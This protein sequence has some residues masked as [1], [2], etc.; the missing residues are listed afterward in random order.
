MVKIILA[1]TV[2]LLSQSIFAH[3]VPYKGAVGVM[4]WNQP[5]MSDNWL[6][7]SFRP[8]MAVAA[9]TMRMEMPGEE[10]RYHGAQLDYLLYRKNASDY[11]ANVY[12]YGGGGEVR[13]DGKPGSASMVGGEVDAESRKYFVMLKAE[14]M[15][16][17]VGS[18]FS[19]VEARVGIAPYEAEYNEVASWFMVQAQWHSSLTRHMAVTPL[20]RFYYKSVL[21]ET[22]VSTDGDWMLN[23]MFHL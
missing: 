5:F 3:P 1:L 21:W 4:T 9:R 18:E 10:F 13:V 2:V 11:Q 20:A 8:D 19:H 6:T 23:F 17:T 16:P 12:L 14:Q 7:Y 15:T 22:G